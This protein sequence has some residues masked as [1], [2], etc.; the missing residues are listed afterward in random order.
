MER[1]EKKIDVLSEKLDCMQKLIRVPETVSV[2]DIASMKGM[3]R[4]DLLYNKPYLLPDYGRSEFPVGK[5]RW[6]LQRYAEWEKIPL[7]E[8]IAGWKA[9]KERE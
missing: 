6:T 2:S 8:R 4:T 7:E 9:L 5:K 3:S 1:L